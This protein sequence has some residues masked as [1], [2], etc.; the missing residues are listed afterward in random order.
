MDYRY[1]RNG[2]S[3]WSH[4]I[5]ILFHSENARGRL[6]IRQAAS[7]P[8]YLDAPFLGL[9]ERLDA[10]RQRRTHRPKKRPRPESEWLIGYLIDHWERRME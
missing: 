6:W 1:W 10:I 8:A 9:K 2:P 7:R 4:S 3:L 5:S